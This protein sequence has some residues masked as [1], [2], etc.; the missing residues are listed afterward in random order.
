MAWP[1]PIATTAKPF[2]LATCAA[3][4]SLKIGKACSGL[5]YE[6]GVTLITADKQ[7]AKAAASLGCLADEAL[8]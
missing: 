8:G 2:F 4:N 1:Y 5:A 6:H 7:L 3:V